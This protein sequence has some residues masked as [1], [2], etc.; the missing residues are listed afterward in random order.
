LVAGKNG[1]KITA[2]IKTGEFRHSIEDQAGTQAAELW[3]EF[4]AAQMTCN[5]AALANIK[6]HFPTAY[7][8]MEQMAQDMAN[9]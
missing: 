7:E 2:D 5:E 8:A 4:F 9:S 1:I 6:E 3:A